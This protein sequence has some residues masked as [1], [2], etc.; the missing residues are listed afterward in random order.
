M[1][2]LHRSFI[3]LAICLA[4]LLVSAQGLV[5][6]SPFLP[7]GFGLRNEAPPSQGAPS[8]PT[9]FVFRGFFSIDDDVRVLVKAKD[10]KNGKWIRV[11][12]TSSTPHVLSFDPDERS[13]VLVNNGTELKLDMIELAANTAPMPV[14]GQ[15]SS[16]PRRTALK[17][18][19]KKNTNRTSIRRRTVPPRRPQWMEDRLRE[20]G[21]PQTPS[22]IPTQ[23]PSVPAGGFPTK[24]PP[25]PTTTP[26]FPT[27]LTL[28]GEGPPEG[29]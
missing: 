18:S 7:P 20:Q 19:A 24:I 5:D 8:A 22:Q 26:Q 13:L 16:T 17:R 1:I 11:G 21:N 4:P 9:D 12:D 23:A 2:H 14:T 27:A 29:P 3:S 6:R 25:P 10:E 15:S 28:P